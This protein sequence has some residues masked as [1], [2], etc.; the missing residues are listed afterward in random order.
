M[1]L[2]FDRR[3]CSGSHAAVIGRFVQK[4]RYSIFSETILIGLE[5]VP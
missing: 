4:N 1:S 3:K 2:S 5:S